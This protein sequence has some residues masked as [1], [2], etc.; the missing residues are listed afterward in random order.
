M[1]KTLLRSL[2]LATVLAF[3]VSASAH[4]QT[5]TAPHYRWAEKTDLSLAVQTAHRTSVGTIVGRWSVPDFTG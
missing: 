2:V 4:A 5:C 1:E 3:T